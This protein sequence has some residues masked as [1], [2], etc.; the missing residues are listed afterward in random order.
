[1]DINLFR[2]SLASKQNILKEESSDERNANRT[3]RDT[4]KHLDAAQTAL[5]YAA[6]SLDEYISYATA[7]KVFAPGEK[8]SFQT[9]LRELNALIKQLSKVDEK[10]PVSTT[11]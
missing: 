10:I 6:E 8:Q 4:N 11:L 9:A 5:E 7:A 3:L 1:M 2:K